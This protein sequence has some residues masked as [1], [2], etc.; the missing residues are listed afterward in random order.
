MSLPTGHLRKSPSKQM[1][2][3]RA[4]EEGRSRRQKC[5]GTGAPTRAVT[6]MSKERGGEDRPEESPLHS[7]TKDG[8]S[9]CRGAGPQ[10]LTQNAKL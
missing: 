10:G 8:D 4:R 9:A 1:V 7:E 6:R 2:L 3:G 5:G